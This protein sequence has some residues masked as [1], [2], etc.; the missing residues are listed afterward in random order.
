MTDQQDPLWIAWWAKNLDELDR[1][2]AREAM[3]CDVKLLDAG[4]IDRVLR[5]DAS[6][7][8]VDNPAA[9]AKLC[10]LVR[11]HFAMRKKSVDAIGAAQTAQI[12]T[13][14]IERL[15]KAFASL[16]GASS[17]SR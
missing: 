6:V 5:N 17:P 1:E 4:V 8:G 7:C 15:R 10:N 3:L 14:V 12:E 16:A 13:H 11:M 2:I 9:F